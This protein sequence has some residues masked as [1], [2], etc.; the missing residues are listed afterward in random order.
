MCIRD[1]LLILQLIFFQ[2]FILLI[3]WEHS[4][5]ELEIKPSV[6][7]H[8]ILILSERRNCNQ[9]LAMPNCIVGI[10]QASMSVLLICMNGNS[11]SQ[12]INSLT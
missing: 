9:I 12:N 1:R 11:S 10:G 3:F 4:I 6:P 5:S 2:I 8:F 7:L